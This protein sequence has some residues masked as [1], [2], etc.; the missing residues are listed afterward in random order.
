MAKQRSDVQLELLHAQDP[1][2]LKVHAAF[3]LQEIEQRQADEASRILQPARQILGA[4]AVPHQF[5][6]RNCAACG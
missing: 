1:M 5:R 2:P 4:E 6:W 3:S